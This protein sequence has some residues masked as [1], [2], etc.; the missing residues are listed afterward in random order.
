MPDLQEGYMIVE[1]F[2]P[3]TISIC[4]NPLFT[5]APLK[6]KPKSQRSNVATIPHI[7]NIDPFPSSSQVGLN[8][9]IR[10]YTNSC[11]VILITLAS[12]THYLVLIYCMF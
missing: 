5:A 9:Q 8:Q 4:T 7:T 6:L 3:V 2:P 12:F 11:T 1:I 10:S